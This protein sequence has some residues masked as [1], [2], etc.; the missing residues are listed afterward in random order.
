MKFKIN[1]AE[2]IIKE[3]SEAEINNEMKNDFTLG[4]AIYCQKI[5]KRE[6]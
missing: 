5:I 3:I 4:V 2:W 1:N 6:I